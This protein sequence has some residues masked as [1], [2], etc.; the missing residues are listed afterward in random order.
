MNYFGKVLCVSAVASMSVFMASCGGGGIKPVTTAV[1]GTLGEYFTVVDKG[2]SLTTYTDKAKLI[3]VQ[4]NRTDKPLPFD[5]EKAE[6]YSGYN[7]ERVEVS[8]GIEFLDANDDV[9]YKVSPTDAYA[10][11]RGSVVED[12]EFLVAIK[13]ASGD[14]CSIQFGITNEDAKKVKKFRV[15]SN[16]EMPETVENTVNT[17][18]DSYPSAGAAMEYEEINDEPAEDQQSEYTDYPEGD[19]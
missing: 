11:L 17:A 9:V 7:K 4:L 2:Y 10:D 15:L 3:T 5:A 16:L 12:D 13:T 6:V 18:S 8:F 1:S 19:L 14:R